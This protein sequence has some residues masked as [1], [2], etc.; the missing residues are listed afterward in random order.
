MK[1][2]ALMWLISNMA[3]G[4]LVWSSLVSSVASLPTNFRSA[5]VY[6][7]LQRSSSKVHLKSKHAP[8]EQLFHHGPVKQTRPSFL[9]SGNFQPQP[10]P[11][12]QEP[13]K[14]ATASRHTEAPLAGHVLGLAKEPGTSISYGNSVESSLGVGKVFALSL[15]AFVLLGLLLTF[16]FGDEAHGAWSL[17]NEQ[18]PRKVDELPITSTRTANTKANLLQL[19]PSP[20]TWA[21]TYR[22]ADKSSKEALEL[23]FRCN[24]IPMQEFAHSYVSQEHIDECVWISTQML[25]QKSLEDWVAAWPQAMK[26]FEESVTA[27]FAART[28]VISN[29]YGNSCP[30]S[31]NSPRS[32][33]G[34]MDCKTPGAPSPAAPPRHYRSNVSTAT[35]LTEEHAPSTYPPSPSPPGHRNAYSRPSAAVILSSKSIS[36]DHAAAALSQHVQVRPPQ[37]EFEDLLKNS[38][39]RT[40]VVSRCREIMKEQEQEH[41]SRSQSNL[42]HLRVVTVDDSPPDFSPLVDQNFLG[43]SSSLPPIRLEREPPVA[44]RLSPMLSSVPPSETTL[45]GRE[46]TPPKGTPF[47]SKIATDEPF[48]TSPTLDPSSSHAPVQQGLTAPVSIEAPV[49]SGQ[50][51]RQN[52]P[53]FGR[54]PPTSVEAPTGTGSGQVLKTPLFVGRSSQSSVQSNILASSSEDPFRTSPRIE[55]LSVPKA[56]FEGLGVPKAGSPLA[57]GRGGSPR[58]G[59]Q[60]TPESYG[61]AV[62]LDKALGEESVPGTASTAKTSPRLSGKMQVT[63]LNIPQGRPQ[64]SPYPAPPDSENVDQMSESSASSVRVEY[65]GPARFALMPDEESFPSLGLA[66]RRA[67]DM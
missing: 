16:C 21:K 12:L 44:R 67:A 29:L 17:S 20:G 41:C 61:I 2:L 14:T 55:G 46:D 50:A 47:V 30:N 66:P 40:S 52:T 7:V 35:A 49:P 28:D 10:P 13:S 24:I 56:G 64:A 53:I 32:D 9:P 8:R 11:G 63:A 4:V 42:I 15:F 58:A 33:R 25:R 36:E 54:F 45:G 23:L 22:K 51:P 39:G 38:P 19:E 18:T 60:P 1:I 31:P 48:T 26:T 3:Q 65:D 57:S 62:R 5:E 27:C 43:S 6:S 37:E 34:F 59:K